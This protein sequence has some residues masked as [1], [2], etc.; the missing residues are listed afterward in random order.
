MFNYTV[1]FRYLCL[2]LILSLSL[3]KPLFA[4]SLVQVIKKNKPA[5]VGIGIHRPISQPKNTL[6]GTGFA[7]GSGAYIV[8]NDHVLPKEL[9]VGLHQKI[10]VFIGSGKDA[11]V[12]DATVIDR[13][14]EHDL[15]LLKISGETLKAM[16]LSDKSYVDEGS[17]IAFTGFPIGAVLG[18][19]PVTHQ[20][21]VS[22]VTPIVIPV[23][24]AK[25]ITIK[26]LKR[27]RDPYMV[28]QL[29]AVAYPGNSGSA[30]YKADTGEVI[31]VI[32]KV[33]IQGTK[34]SAIKTPSGITYAIP[35]RYVHELL[36]RNNINF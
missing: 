2:C 6:L 3:V 26:M 16:V 19:Y 33:F 14:K 18:L 8:T 9:D 36:E 1:I 20:G 25:K 30:L 12:R 15:A 35:V 7:I 21:I 24:D 10:V 27:L 22:A 5:V 28:Y 17:A 4:D 11:Q 34:E 31:G 13:N 29:D 32:N 23:N